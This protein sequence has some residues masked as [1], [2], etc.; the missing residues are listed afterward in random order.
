MAKLADVTSEVRI[1]LKI[2]AGALVTIVALF[3]FLKGGQI[4]KA[5]FFPTPPA[6]PKM[7]FG[8][9]PNPSFPK[10]NKLSLDYQIN[11]VDGQLPPLPDR[12]NVYKVVTNEPSLVALDNARSSLRG[13]GFTQGEEK[14]NDSI[15]QWSNTT[16]VNVQ[17]NIFTNNFQVSSDVASSPPPLGISLTNDI[18]LQ[19]ATNLLDNLSENSSD[20]N[21]ANYKVIYLALQNGQLGKVSSADQAQAAQI[22][23]FQN[24]I[25]KYQ[26]YYQETDS[27]SMNFIFEDEGG[28]PKLVYGKYFHFTPDLKTFSDYPIKTAQQAFEDLKNDN[29][30]VSTTLKDGE[31]ADILNVALGYYIGEKNES[32]F[33]PVIVFSGNNFTAYVNAIP[34]ELIS[35]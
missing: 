27:S 30:Y 15:Y 25:N 24:P 23:L 5:L 17:Y 33:L 16:G 21:Q 29:A 13:V 32:Y 31:T 22:N 28:F 35:Q 9:L 8:K 19:S 14:I 6:P 34:A 4:F 26:V 7:E 18:L 11:T 12:I 1:I 10:Q 2:L 3:L 20:I